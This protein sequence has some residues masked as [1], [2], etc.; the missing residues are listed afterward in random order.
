MNIFYIHTDPVIAAQA[1][2][3]KHVVKMILES[4]QLLSTA[5]R[6]LDGQEFIQLS[7]SG[8]RLRKWN[9]PN[10]HMDMTLYKSTHLNHPSGIWVRQSSDNY[11]WLYNHFIALSEEYYQRYG[12]RHASEL[13]LSGLLSKVPANIPRIGL[14]PMLVAITDTQWHVPNNALQSYRNYYVGE[15]LKTPKDTDRYY[16]VLGLKEAKDES[17]VSNIPQVRELL[18]QLY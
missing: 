7:K 3:D 17:K 6:A 10:Q 1:M 5:H 14:T 8:A 16:K 9:H 12:K 2:T 4:A 13:L 11:M 18:E 15:K